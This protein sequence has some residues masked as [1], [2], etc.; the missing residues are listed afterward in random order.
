MKLCIILVCLFSFSLSA[1]TL[2]QRERV[3]MK[4]QDVSLRQVLEQIREQTKLQFMMSKEQGERVGR[5]S[6]DAVNETVAEVLDKIFASTGL[7]WVVKED[8]IVVKEQPQQQVQDPVRVKGVVKDKKGHTLPGVTV[9]IKGTIMGV[10]TDEDGNYSIE[11]PDSQDI[12]LIFSFIGMKAQEVAYTGQKEINVTLHEDITE[13][14]EVVVTGYRTMKKTSMAGSSSSVKAED[15]LLTGTQTLEQALQGKLAGVSIVNQSGLT[16]TRQK[17]RVRGTSTLV[18]NA[19]PV[20]V[21]DGIIQEDP[22]PFNSSELTDIGNTDADII[23]NFIGGAISW[24]NPNDI[25]NITVLKDASATAIYGVKAANGVIVITTKKGERGRMS[26]NYSGSFSVSPRLTYKKM[27][28]MNSKQRV[29]ASREAFNS[30]AVLRS[31]EPI[32]YMGLATAY[33][34]REISF[35]EFNAGVKQLETNNTD[36]FD[37]LFQTPFSHSHSLSVSGGSD[38]T[39]YRASFGY[40]DTKNTAIGNEQKAYSGNLNVSSTFWDKLYITFGLSGSL[41]KTKAFNGSDP[42]SYASTTNRAIPCF[43]DEGERYFYNQGSGSGFYNILHELENSGNRNSSNSINGNLNLRWV[44]GSG[45]TLSSILG[46]NYSMT[47]GESWYTEQSNYIRQIRGYEFGEFG[48]GDTKYKESKLPFGGVLTVNETENTNYTWRNQLEFARTFGLHVVNALVGQEVRSNQYSGYSMTN[49]GYMPERGKSFADVPLLIGPDDQRKQNDLL[50]SNYPNLTDRTA[51]YLSFYGDMSYMFDNRYAINASIRTDASNRFGQ[52]KS[53]RYLPVWS[54]GLRWNMGRE[55]WLDNQNLL[56]EFSLRATYGWQ[57]NVVENVGPD[58]IAR[59]ERVDITTGEYKMT[60]SRLPTPDLKWEKNKSIN[61]GVDFSL[62]D[63]RVNGSFEWYYKRTEDMI[64]SRQV[65][66]ENG[67]TTLYLNGGDMSNRGWDLTFSFVPVRTKHFVWNVSMNTSRSTNEVKTDLEPTS[68]WRDATG[69]GYNK[70]GY[71]VSSFWAFRF[72]GL[73]PQNGAPTFDLAGSEKESAERDATEY[74]VY[75]GKLDPDFTAGLNTGFRYKN[76]YLSASFYLSTG[77]QKFLA[78]PYGEKNAFG[79][80]TARTM[81]SE[82]KN[83]ST[84]LLSRWRKPGDERVT[85][86]PVL[87]NPETSAAIYPFYDNYTPLYPYEAWAYSDIRVVDAWYL[88]CNNISLSYSVPQK[89]IK[90]FASS[91]NLSCSVSNPFQIV[92][93]DFLGRDPEVASGAQPLSRNYSLS[94]NVSF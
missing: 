40:T 35:A 76:L 43:D 15:L 75:A 53:A 31:D 8:I 30:G 84:Q 6:V 28:L 78:S 70:N 74:L 58:L 39:T 87:P 48:P 4:L 25:D 42:Y 20:W 60:I 73:N 51:N 45:F 14:D 44:I 90:G 61:L 67:T 66:Y 68:N 3:S 23:K 13:M 47:Y 12:R 41:A 72:N 71:P 85:K 21:V 36:W 52:D 2:A 93:K 37:L 82:Y 55:H 24:L 33:K 26:L 49:Y 50:V 86:I 59:I 92:S 83:L 1:T 10:V 64:T 19:E 11:L 80:E 81:A 7:T 63:S 18:G 79:D 91:V 9:L 77:N 54:V 46:C 32:G 65:P 57:G 62:L 27:E 34:R 22:L 38:K 88:R 56:N 29:D 69:G 17:V 16:G 5:V 89:W 94:V